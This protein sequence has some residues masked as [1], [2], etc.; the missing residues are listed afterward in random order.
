MRD[1]GP[2]RDLD[3]ALAEIQSIR[4]QVARTVEFRGYGPTTLATTGV[5]AAAA[6]VVQRLWLPVPGAHLTAYLALWIGAAAISVVVVGIETVARSRRVHF[7]LAQEMIQA[8]AEQFLPAGL[9]GA[10][11]TAAVTRFAPESV[12]MLPGLWQ[13]V[14]ALGV[15]ASGRFLPR[16]M[17]LV[18]G[19]YLA[20]GT[21]CLGLAR[22]AHALTPWAMGAPFCLGQ[23]A[24]AAM[25][26][27]SHGGRK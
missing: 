18:G 10:A 23:L 13:I 25:L 4:S 20:T 6:A 9:A 17:L 22:G 26:Q 21:A 19:W 2:M 15:F 11:L 8:A 27:L 14:F 7:G 3:R 24:M 16:A 12:W 5:L 1:L